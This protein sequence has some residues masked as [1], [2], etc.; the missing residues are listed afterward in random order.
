MKKM[1]II[2][3]WV[4]SYGL[5]GVLPASACGDKLLYMSRIYRHH[6]LNNTTIAVYA[7]PH[8]LLENTAS[9]KLDKA[10]QQEGYHLLVVNSQDDLAV[11]IQSGVPDV[12][13]ADLGDVASIDPLTAAAKI[14][15]IPVLTNEEAKSATE[16]K[17]F[18]ASIKAPVNSD[19][20]LDALDHAFELKELRTNR[21]PI[22]VSS[23][24]FR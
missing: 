6:E 14:P 12:V 16:K 22:R 8:S 11:A 10:F 13:V 19:K 4:V 2:S 24:T 7:R 3:A 5:A 9:L 18:G 1:A 15:I 23:A 21:A 17:H 20:F